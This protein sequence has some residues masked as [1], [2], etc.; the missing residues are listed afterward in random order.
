MF[1]APKKKKNLTDHTTKTDLKVAFQSSKKNTKRKLITIV[2]SESNLKFS[3]FRYFKT[4][5]HYV[6]KITK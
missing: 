6:N 5:K 3:N 2:L 4:R 1:I